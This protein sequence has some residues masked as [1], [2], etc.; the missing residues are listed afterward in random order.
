MRHGSPLLA[1]LSRRELS[2]MLP[3]FA[4]ILLLP[5]TACSD[6]A[7]SKAATDA[8]GTGTVGTFPDGQEGPVRP[9]VLSIEPADLSTGLDGALV[10]PAVVVQSSPYGADQT[11]VTSGVELQADATGAP[12]PAL[13]AS[14]STNADGGFAYR[15]TPDPP[16]AEGWYTLLVTPPPNSYVADGAPEGPTGPTL[17]ADGRYESHFR[18]GS[19]PLLLA[20]AACASNIDTELP[21][22]IVS[23]SEPVQVSDPL[24]IQVMVDGSSRSC[25]I[26]DPGKTKLGLTCDPA[27]PSTSDISV[28]ISAGITSVA[29]GSPL[30]D[31]SGQ[32]QISIHLPAELGQSVCRTWRETWVP[33]H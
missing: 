8:G 24:P 13:G 4:V 22:L 19:E 11:W 26:Y 5:A 32:T 1:R 3:V 17:R 28:S 27:I 16:L 33:G 12:A 31:M 29:S 18:V 7:S 21:K 15:L 6:S 30:R 25:A 10:R 23:F 14:N 9:T 2:R 20:I